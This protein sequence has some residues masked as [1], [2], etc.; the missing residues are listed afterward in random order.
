MARA[1]RTIGLVLGLLTA[2]VANAQ[3][4]R[5]TTDAPVL[6]RLGP[7]G[8]GLR[9]ITL[10]QAAQVDVLA[11]RPSGA[12]PPTLKDRVLPVEVWYPARTAKGA[13][14]VTYRYALPAEPPR[15]PVAF[16]SAGLAV[17]GAPAS[18]GRFPLVI[19]SHGYS[20]APEAMSW[21]A[22]N[23]A[24]NGYV[25]A[26]I[27]HNDPNY[28]DRVR[29][30]E[31]MARR[32]LDIAFVAGALRARIAAGTPGLKDA[33]A[34]RVVLI[35]SSMGGYG[36]LTA[37][38]AS[39]EP[40]GLPVAGVPGRPL[41]DFVRGGPRAGEL[42]VPGVKA[43]VAISPAGLRFGAWG[44]TGLSGVT[45][46]L[47][48]I[49]GTR[50]ATVGFA[51]GI[52]PVFDQALHAPRYL[53][54]FQNAGHALGLDPAPA[55]AGSQLW[56]FQWFEDPVWRKDRILGISQHM[57]TAFVDRYAKGDEAK[58]AYL[59]SDVVAGGDGAW[60][61]GSPGGY[62]AISPGGPGATWKGFYR[63]TAIGLELRRKPAAP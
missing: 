55:E 25:V 19:V 14:G 57:I 10:V 46:P 59:D 34:S 24:S 47:L 37:A 18:G 2:G 33:D 63:N 11:A 26:A 53:L 29:A 28:S 61:A 17:R 50:D 56:D 38:G 31:P 9:T 44:A 39:L 15:G 58:A 13:K 4:S 51:D 22:E 36:V 43:V 27:H 49:G 3:P 20:N 62:A 1:L 41:A 32:P 6:A 60:P 40:G 21:L 42:V 8:V 35:G 45:A 7:Y 5:P 48:V 16:S 12:A 52:A 23:L 30:A 54:V